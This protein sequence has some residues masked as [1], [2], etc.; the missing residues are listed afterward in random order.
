VA[1]ALR[2]AREDLSEIGMKKAVK[3]W[4]TDIHR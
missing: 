4:K 3:D 1:L 2:A